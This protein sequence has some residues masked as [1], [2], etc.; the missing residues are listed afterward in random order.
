MP[1]ATLLVL[2]GCFLAADQV[3]ENAVARDVEA[4]QGSWLFILQS[5]EVVDGVEKELTA[6]GRIIITHV[7]F[8]MFIRRDG[9]YREYSKGL[10]KIDTTT[11]PKS[12]DFQ[13]FVAESPTLG[14]YELN[15]NTLQIC[16]ADMPKDNRPKQF[17]PTR[18][19]WLMTLQ[20]E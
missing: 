3:K 14:I 6:Q 16:I 12:I 20:K 5:K 11:T 17:K 15:G 8:H 1:L 18:D 2:A 9:E 10:F 19:L 4:L 7:G 13:P